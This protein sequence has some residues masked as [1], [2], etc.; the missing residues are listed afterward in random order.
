LLKAAGMSLR[1]G[2]SFLLGAAA[3]AASAGAVRAE[4]DACTPARLMIV[5][6]KSSSMQTGTIAGVTKWNIAKNAI[7]QVATGYQDNLQLGLDIFPQPDEC[8]AGLV[9]VNPALGNRNP[10]MSQLSSPPPSAG[11]W[12]PISQTLEALALYPAMT[13]PGAPAYA[14]LVTDGWQWC[15]PYDASTRFDGVDAISSM[16]AAGITTFV[17]GFGG[18]VDALALNQM[19]VEAGTARPGCDPSGDTPGLADACYFSASSPAELLAALTD[20]ADTSSAEICDGQD[21]DCDGEV[22][23]GLTEACATACGS[24]VETCVNGAWTG[25]D[26]P[27]VVTETC[28]GA[29]DDCDGA[30]DPGCDCVTGDSRAC[31]GDEETGA[32]QPGTQTCVGGQWGGC[33]GAVGPTGETC[34]GI[35]DDCDGRTD[36][37]SDD[38]ST[39]CG[40]GYICTDGNC[41]PVDP[42]IPPEPDDPINPAV[43]DGSPAG[44]CGCKTTGPSDQLGGLLLALGSAFLL[45]RR[46]R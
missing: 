28:N 38:V 9:L 33:E 13:S 24:G 4:P 46:R 32:C 11:N 42:T 21:N 23:E 15:D 34:N 18:A 19:A 45:R 35:D 12:T 22:D 7:D 40:A 14:V 26:A 39:L 37:T 1:R 44:G 41:E 30:T 25:C 8:G 36:E 20:I 5:L 17:V 31:G 16:N 6:D 10:I 3:L 43:D 27:P 29:D 2:L